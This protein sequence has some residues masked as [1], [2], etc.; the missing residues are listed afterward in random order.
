MDIPPTSK[1][2]LVALGSDAQSARWTEFVVK[3]EPLMRAYLRGHFPGVPEEDVM[4]DTLADLVRSLPNYRYAPEEKGLFRNY[5]LGILRHKSI[6]YLEARAREREA[7]NEMARLNQARAEEEEEKEF[8]RSVYEVALKELLADESIRPR[9]K[10]ILV[11]V[12]VN[13]E[14]PAAVAEAYGVQRNTV[15]QIK[16]RM[17]EKLSE[18]AKRLSEL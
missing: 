18:I 7:L 1:R 10:Q 5:L 15:D 11:R 3:Y 12:I 8:L 17:L 2:L 9:T 14:S 4:Q 13:G 16:S 6:R